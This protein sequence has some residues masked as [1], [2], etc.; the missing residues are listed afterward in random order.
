MDTDWYLNMNSNFI[1]WAWS[2]N[3]PNWLCF[4]RIFTRITRGPGVDTLP[5]LFWRPSRGSAGPSSEFRDIVLEIFTLPKTKKPAHE[6]EWR[7]SFA[8]EGETTTKNNFYILFLPRCSFGEVVFSNSCDKKKGSSLFHPDIPLASY[9]VTRPGVVSFRQQQHT[10]TAPSAKLPWSV[11][12]VTKVNMTTCHSW[13]W[14]QYPGK[15]W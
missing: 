10:S 13:G 7:R 3:D 15:Q 5:N 9:L 12:K 14:N 6:N 1:C 2:K 11:T 8:G 4:H